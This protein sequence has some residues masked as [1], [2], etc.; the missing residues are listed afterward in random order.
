[1]DCLQHLLLYAYQSPDDSQPAGY[2]KSS[3]IKA[4]WSLVDKTKKD[5]HA[6][7]GYA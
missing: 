2:L 6:D 7:N 1:M 5:E 3:T 4:I